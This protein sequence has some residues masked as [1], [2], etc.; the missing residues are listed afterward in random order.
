MLPVSY[1]GFLEKRLSKRGKQLSYSLSRNLSSSI[2]RIANTRAEQIG[3]YRFLNNAIVTEDVLIEEQRQRC[4]HLSSQ[5]VVLC[6]SDTTEA[7]FFNHVNRLKPN[8]GLGYTAASNSGIGFLAHACF[9]LDARS[10]LP[11]G[12]SDLKIW[13]RINKQSKTD[14]EV[15]RLP[16]SQ[17]ESNRWIQGCRNSDK[18]LSQAA[19]VIHIQDREA[20]IYEQLMD[21]P[22]DGKTFYIIRSSHN[23]TTDKQYRLY[24]QLEQSDPIGTYNLKLSGEGNSKQHQG[25]VTMEVRM[26]KSR[27][28]RPRERGITKDLKSFTEE[29]TLIET[30]QTG[31]QQGEERI[32]WRLLTTCTVNTLQDAYQVIE[33]YTS[34]WLIEE[35]FRVVKKENFNIE[36]SEL[37]TGWALRKLFVLLVDTAIKLFQFYICRDI[38]EG[39][40][41]N[42]IA[43]FSPDEF[44][45][46]EKLQQSLEGTT[47]KQKNPYKLHSLQWVIWVLSRMGGWKGYRSQ[48]KPGLS[49]IINGLDKFYHFYNGWKL[50]NSS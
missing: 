7:N 32:C 33:W 20:D 49:T 15:Y 18:T 14:D 11:Y 1:E 26:I 2:Q 17:K 8:T 3:F 47:S 6:I 31:V 10:Y 4:S 12:I 5:R 25:T 19:S 37:E 41:P 40:T 44:T 22:K 30:R 16:I 29:I 24:E 13:H 23:R 35:L 45:C 43:S 28:K 42:S 36:A 48:R 21:L 46:L 50:H 38:E 9:V 39:E 27:I 34:R